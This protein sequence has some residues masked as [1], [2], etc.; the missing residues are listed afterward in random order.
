VQKI[1]IFD[2]LGIPHFRK[3]PIGV[4]S[5]LHILHLPCSEAVGQHKDVAKHACNYNRVAAFGLFFLF[6]HSKLGMLGSGT[7]GVAH[8]FQSVCKYVQIL[9]NTVA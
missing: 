3:A 6:Q 4:G 5:T 1:S 8:S 9:Y 2:D 7:L